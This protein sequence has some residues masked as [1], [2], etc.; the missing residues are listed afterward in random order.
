MSQ[1]ASTGTRYGQDNRRRAFPFIL[2]GSE[3]D[4]TFAV[5]GMMTWSRGTRVWR[6]ASRATSLYSVGPKDP[7][8]DAVMRIGSKFRGG[9]PI[10]KNG[11]E[12]M[13]VRGTPPPRTVIGDPR[14]TRKGAETVRCS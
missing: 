1:A 11:I 12:A 5:V 4:G 7:D 10:L 3:H 2:D 9:G 8:H 14:R 6:T 13:G